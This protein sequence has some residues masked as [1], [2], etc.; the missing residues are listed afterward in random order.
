MDLQSPSIYPI[1]LSYGECISCN[2]RLKFNSLRII[3]IYRPPK[4]DFSIFFDEF[5]D[6]INDALHLNAYKVI[7]VGDFNYHFDS[8]SSPHTLHLNS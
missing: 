4:A 5:H 1:A 3:V 8:S 6:L 7:I 2:F